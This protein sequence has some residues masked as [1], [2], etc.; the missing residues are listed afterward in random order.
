MYKK[1][2]GIA[3]DLTSTAL[4][5][6]CNEDL[7]ADIMRDLQND[8]ASMTEG[9]LLAAIKHLAVNEESTLVHRINLSKMTQAPVSGRYKNVPSKSL[10]TGIPL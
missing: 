2:M 8:I 5:H 1:G 6:C 4:Y 3:E 10:R 9:N 7:Q